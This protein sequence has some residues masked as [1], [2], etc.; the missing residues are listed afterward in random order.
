MQKMKDPKD[1][2]KDL[3]YV[4]CPNRR[5]YHVQINADE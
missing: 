3:T 5:D 1:K 2:D 4:I